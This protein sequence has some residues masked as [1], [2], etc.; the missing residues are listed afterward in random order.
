MNLT[1]LQ[2]VIRNEPDQRELAGGERAV[3]LDLAVAG[4]DGTVEPVPV[5]IYGNAS[6]PPAGTEVVVIGRVRKRFYRTGAA[7]QSRTEV[8]ASKLVATRKS[9]QAAKAIRTAAD[10]LAQF[11]RVG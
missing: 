5:V 11:R 3:S 6:I 10:E 1:I 4:P 2:G 9:L 8:V 7:T